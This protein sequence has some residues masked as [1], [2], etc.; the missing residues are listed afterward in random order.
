[1]E[2]VDFSHYPDREY[3]L[4][5]LRTFLELTAAENGRPVSDVTAVDVERLYVQVNKFSLVRTGF[6][7]DVFFSLVVV[8]ICVTHL[9]HISVT[10]LAL[11]CYMRS[12]N[13]KILLFRTTK[14][15]DI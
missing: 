9:A 13:K 10:V 7:P 5:W 2:V 1:M 3:Q 11:A 6:L 15:C 14:C 12:W 4:A 8:Q